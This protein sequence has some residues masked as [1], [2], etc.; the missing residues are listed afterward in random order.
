MRVLLC[1]WLC[2]SAE[3]SSLRYWIEP[4][5]NMESGCHRDDP[6]LAQWALDAWQAASA[7]HLTL[8]KV[9][10]RD[11]AHIRIYWANGRSGLYGETRPISVDGQRGAE[12]YV[13]P[14]VVPAGVTDGLLRDAIVYLTCLHETGHALGLEHTADFADIMY[15]FQYGGDIPEY[16]ARYRRQLASRTDI[17]KHP[18][19]SSADRKRL[20]ELYR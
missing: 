19:M 5:S 6:E 7:G 18:G 12:V 3:C 20:V 16:F 13:L 8:E 14:T 2:A 10:D 17:R 1:L 9:A 15:S 11:Q 4:C